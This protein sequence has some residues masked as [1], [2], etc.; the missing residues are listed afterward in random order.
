MW[1]SSAVKRNFLSRLAAIRTPSSPIDATLVRL[2]VRGA[3]FL[4]TFPLATRLP[5]TISAGSPIGLLPL[6]D[7]F[8]GTTHVSDFSSAWTTGLWLWALPVP[9]APRGSGTDE[10]SQ[11]ACRSLPG[12]LRVSDRAESQ[13]VLRL[14]SCCVWPS[15]IATPWAP[16]LIDFAAQWMACRCPL[17]TLRSTPRGV[18]RMT[19]GLSD[20]PCLP[21]IELSSTTIYRLCWRTAI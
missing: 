1:C 2:G 7:G 10:I 20:S 9:P 21:S 13:H 18:Q 14:T 8:S 4:L 12:M 16:R 19:R 5:S 3:G 6:F 15:G 11:L 17:S